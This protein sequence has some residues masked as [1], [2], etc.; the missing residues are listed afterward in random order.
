MQGKRFLNAIVLLGLFLLVSDLNAKLKTTFYGYQWLRYEYKLIGSSQ[1]SVSDTSG[2]SIPRTY[3]RWKVADK[4]AGYSGNITLDVVMTKGGQ[5]IS[6]TTAS[7]GA[8]DADG[9]GNTITVEHSHTYEKASGKI[10][11]ALWV[12]YG[13]VEFTKIPLLSDI[14]AKLITGL[15]KVYFGVV[16]TW[17]YPLIEKALEDRYHV[18]SSADLGCG[19]TGYL[20]FDLGNYQVALYNGS[21]YKKLESNVE[22]RYIAS[23]TLVP[24]AGLYMRAS[25][26]KDITSNFGAV[27]SQH[28]SSTALVLG[29][30]TGPIEGWVEYLVKNDDSKYVQG[31]KSG[32]ALGYAGFIKM[33]ITDL[34]D[35]NFLYQEFDADTK[36]NNDEVQTFSTGINFY[37]AGGKKG[38]IIALNYQLDNKKFATQD[39][40]RT[41]KWLVQTKWNY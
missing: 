28:Y 30:A 6:T 21:G 19:I 40:E 41:N 32:V 24:I 31:S 29:G 8:T 36:V 25:Y 35:V 2:F 5:Q 39:S 11:W 17:E 13:Y 26:L 38:T 1:D 4:D 15:M 22:K 16:D 33:D 27:P 9:S 14:N 12:K 3:L 34:F 7:T 10:D 18:V 37:V 20:P 23:M